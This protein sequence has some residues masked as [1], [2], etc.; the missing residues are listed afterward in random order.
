MRQFLWQKNVRI[1]WVKPNLGTLWYMV[2]ALDWISSS[3][4]KCECI[5][6]I[7]ILRYYPGNRYPYHQNIKVNWARERVNHSMEFFAIGKPAHC[8]SLQL[9][10]RQTKAFF[11][12]LYIKML[13]SRFYGKMLVNMAINKNT[14]RKNWENYEIMKKM[15]KMNNKYL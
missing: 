3:N 10:Y 9:N 13:I 2:L 8:K 5:C 11:Y 15:V 1:L 14:Q 4:C 12:S 6:S 7:T